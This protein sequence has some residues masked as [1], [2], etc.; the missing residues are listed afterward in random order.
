VQIRKAG[1][2]FGAILGARP[3]GL[4]QTSA[5]LQTWN[6][7]GRADEHPSGACFV[8]PVVHICLCLR[9]GR[10]VV[11]PVRV[12]KLD[13][14]EALATVLP[15]SFLSSTIA[16]ASPVMGLLIS[17]DLEQRAAGRVEIRL[18]CFRRWSG[19]LEMSAAPS[20][21]RCQRRRF[22]CVEDSDCPVWQEQVR[23]GRPCDRAARAPTLHWSG[24]WSEITARSD[25]VG[26]P[27]AGLPSSTGRPS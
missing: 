20:H 2:V 10:T 18:A 13:Q 26:G 27:L 17:S 1:W 16:H 15:R 12:G 14:A 4:H 6:A 3:Y 9:V 8:T 7:G 5:G 25:A 21:C 19:C 24:R 11:I 22:D 23:R